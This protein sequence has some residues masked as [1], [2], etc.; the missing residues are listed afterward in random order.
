MFQVLKAHQ[1]LLH[2]I[3]SAKSRAIR[4]SH[5]GREPATLIG[6]KHVNINQDEY[7]SLQQKQINHELRNC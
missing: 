3:K 5:V 4:E 2:L 6:G 1:V 7:S